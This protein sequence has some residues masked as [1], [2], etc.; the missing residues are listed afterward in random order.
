MDSAPEQV[1]EVLQRFQDGYT[2]RDVGKLEAFMQLFVHSNEIEMIG[3]GAAKRGGGEW[4]QGI[5]QI[6]EI[7]ESDWTYW[8]DVRINVA[9]A[10]INVHGDV[11]WLSADGDLLTNAAFDDALPFYVQ[12][13]K[14]NLEDESRSLKMRVLDAT[15]F[16]LSRLRDIQRGMGFPNAFTFTA[17]LVRA[18]GEWRFH[19]IHWSFPGE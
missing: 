17:V 9:G 15:F 10:K 14:D 11:A 3:V 1:R 16:G 12:M 7:I 6:R 5:D 18:D 2:Y 13:M 19:T 8:G 4:F